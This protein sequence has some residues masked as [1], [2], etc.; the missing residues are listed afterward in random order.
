MN[1]LKHLKTVLKH[2]LYVFKACIDCGILYQGLVHDL[3]KLLPT[4]F[5]SSAK[6]YVGSSSPIEKEKSVIGYSE[7]WQHHKG[8]NKHHW[9]YW[10]DEK[11]GVVVPIKL[12]VKYLIELVCDWIGA[13][14]AYS[15]NWN[16]QEPLSYYNKLKDKLILHPETRILLEDIFTSIATDGWKE[17][18]R[19]LKK[20]N[21]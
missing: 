3:S 13:G 5:F 7:A 14:K 21:K 4:E 17:T 11:N 12:P 9:Q 15:K 10:L 18:S 2:K 19:E 16:E 20:L 6:Y 1:Y 8:R